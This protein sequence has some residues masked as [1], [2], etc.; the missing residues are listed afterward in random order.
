MSPVCLPEKQQAAFQAQLPIPHLDIRRRPLKKMES[1]KTTDY[2]EDIDEQ[3]M[4]HHVFVKNG[5]NRKP[6]KVTR[7][8]SSL[9]LMP[10]RHHRLET[11]RSPSRARRA[12]G[13]AALFDLAFEVKPTPY[14]TTLTPWSV[15][16][17]TA[18]AVVLVHLARHQPDP[19]EIPRITKTA[20][21][22]T[23]SPRQQAAILVGQT[24][25]ENGFFIPF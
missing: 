14:I 4:Q 19:P 16:I 10:G 11:V 23:R 18:A 12:R 13:R 5:E 22:S 24:L 25:V 9:F 8:A 21:R 17:F 3:C 7:T 20:F 1:F 2:N 6:R 15:D